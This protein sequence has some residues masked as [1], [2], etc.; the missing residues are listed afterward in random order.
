MS[1]AV[2]ISIITG[3]FGVIGSGLALLAKANKREHGENS[4]KLDRL[5]EATEGLKHGHGRIEAKIDGHIGDH[6]RGDV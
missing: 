3:G 5:L 4:G 1:D 6:A 2:L